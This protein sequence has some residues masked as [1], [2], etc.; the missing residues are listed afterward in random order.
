MSK[1]KPDKYGNDNDQESF[2]DVNLYLPL[3]DFIIPILH[4]LGFKPNHVTLLST[5]A[6]I[7]SVYCFHN[8]S[9]NCYIFYFIGYLLDCMDGRMARKYNQGSILE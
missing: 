1:N 4:K 7:Y 9:N 6:T 8:K 5:I 3:T 2:A